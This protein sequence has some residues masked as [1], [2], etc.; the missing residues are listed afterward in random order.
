MK[1]FLALAFLAVLAAVPAL[2]QQASLLDAPTPASPAYGARSSE[3]GIIL[4]TRSPLPSPPAFRPGDWLLV[5]AAVP[6]RFFDYRTTEECLSRRS[7]REVM[8]PRSLVG[9][10]AG[11]A[12][13]EAGT[14][15]ANYYVYR[16]L[17]RHH[18]SAIARVGQAINLGALGWTVENNYGV[19]SRPSSSR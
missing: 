14:V 5:G 9:S 4:A 10:H 16:V 18:H 2:A 17:V 15:V 12:A 8:L 13:F 6:L 3:G 1:V 7:C 19:L 11:F